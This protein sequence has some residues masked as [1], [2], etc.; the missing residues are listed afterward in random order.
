MKQDERGFT[1]VELLVVTAIVALIGGATAMSTFQVI[2]VT[3]SS[4]DNM[5]AL[6]QVQN[7]GYWISRDAQMAEDV[8]VDDDPVTPEFLTFSWT[9]WDYEG[10]GENT[11]YHI[12]IY[13]FQD[14]SG[15]IGKLKRQYLIY[16]DQGAEIGNQT[17]MVAENAYYNTAD[18]DDPDN[19]TASYQIP[20]LTF[21]IAA[22]V[23]EASEI[24]EYAVRR[25]PQF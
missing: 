6:R 20:M 18:P 4:N 24:R 12:V 9:E 14:L 5:A 19:T 17:T 25:R 16:D 11:N 7:A 13:S 10:E 3:R 2:N 15:S 21:Q 8:V 1:L 22:S 23:G